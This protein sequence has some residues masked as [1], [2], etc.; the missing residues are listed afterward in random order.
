MGIPQT[1]NHLE[2]APEFTEEQFRELDRWIEEYRGKSG[3]VIRALAKAQE[4]FGCLPREVQSRLAKGLGIPLSEVYGIVTFYS[5][6]SLVPRG[7][8]TISSCQGTACYVRGGKRVLEA[9]EKTL[10]VEVGE[11]TEDRE[12]SLESIRC[13]GAC[14]LAPVVRVDGDVYRRVMPKKV[15]S[16]L[17][18]YSDKCGGD[19]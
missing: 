19:A 10:D 12:Y 13:M 16:I 11:T 4:I 6:F 5:F 14:A 17:R 3:S 1:V 18:N 15:K 9:L 7:K 2:T 8:H